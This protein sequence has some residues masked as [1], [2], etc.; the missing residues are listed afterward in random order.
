MWH[1]IGRR[2]FYSSAFSHKLAFGEIQTKFADLP[3]TPH[4]GSDF[5]PFSQNLPHPFTSMKKVFRGVFLCILISFGH[6]NHTI[7]QPKHWQLGVTTGVGFSKYLYEIPN[8]EIIWNNGTYANENYTGFF[9]QFLVE[10]AFNQNLQMRLS[11][12]VFRK[13]T[14]EIF[15][16]NL[17]EGQ[18]VFAENR[19][20]HLLFAMD[21]ALRY[22]LLSGN[23]R[24]YVLAGIRGG[25]LQ[26]E[27][28]DSEFIYGDFSPLAYSST[29]FTEF[30][31]LVGIGLIA[32]ERLYLEL[33]YNRTVT[34][35]YDLYTDK[36]LTQHLTIGLSY[37]LLSV[38]RP[39]SL[40]KQ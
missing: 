3:P 31:P 28:N 26:F 19:R 7:T 25:Q 27:K 9:A 4:I 39:G 30:G 35:I 21:I 18:R 5:H 37:A 6:L 38:Q 20:S 33:M 10:Y 12:G 34:P 1:C 29:K 13:G 16:S 11:P 22:T 36:V 17:S 8:E 14:T 15:E 24:P 2:T 40:R 32:K 23:F